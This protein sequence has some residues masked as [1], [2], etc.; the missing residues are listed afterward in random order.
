MRFILLGLT[1]LCFATSQADYYEVLTFEDEQVEQRYQNLLEELRCMVCQN[2]TLSDSGAD[3]AQDMRLVV[4]NM[5]NEG[6]TDDDIIAFMVARYGDFV[7]YTPPLDW[8]TSLLWFLPLLVIIALLFA[9]PAML[10][11]QQVAT[12]TEQQKNQLQKILKE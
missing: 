5:I 8:R 12:L 4:Y 7:H 1:L 3:L 9:L 11:R 2:Q 10:K 6:K